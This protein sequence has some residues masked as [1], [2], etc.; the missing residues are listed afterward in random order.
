MLK[1]IIKVVFRNIKRNKWHSILNIGGLSIGL[2]CSALILFYARFELSFDNYH[3]KADRIYRLYNEQPGNSFMGTNNFAVNSAPLGKAM[4]S[5]FPEVESTVNFLFWEGNRYFSVGNKG[6]FEKDIL[7][8][9]PSL[10][11]I[12]DF[13]LLEGNP[14][15]ALTEPN[16]VVLSEDI[17]KKYF[18]NIDPVN[19]TI[20]YNNKIALKVTGVLKKVPQNSHF[21]PTI[22]ISF[23][24]IEKLYSKF[25]GM[26]A[27]GSNSFKTYILLKKNADIN[28]LEKKMPAFLDKYM[29][30]LF[31]E[32]G[33]K[34]YIYHFQPLN[35]VY[36]HS[37]NIN[38]GEGNYNDLQSIYILIALALVI[39]LAACINYVNLSTAKATLKGLEV[40]VRKV[41]GA[42]RKELIRQFLGES[43]IL[44]LIAAVISLLL[45]ELLLPVFSELISESFSSSIIT[46]FP[47]LGSF[48]GL[49]LIVGL[50]A[51]IYPAFVLSSFDPIRVLKGATQNRKSGF[52]SALVVVQFTAAIT[53]IVSSVVILGQLN[54]I[55]TQD[56]G[57]NRDQVLAIKI[58]SNEESEKIEILKNKLLQSTEI[59]NATLT[60]SLPINIGSQSGISSLDNDGNKKIVK[61]YQLY[62]DYDFLDTYEIPVIKGRNFSN[63]FPSDSKNSFIVNQK[64]VDEFGWKDPVG[65]TFSHNDQT[66]KIIGVIK[67]FHMHSLHLPI[68]PLF[69]KLSD[70]YSAYLSLK[71]RSAD[72]KNTV[73]E[74]KETWS[75]IIKNYPIEYSFVNEDFNKMYEKDER[76]SEVVFYSTILAI[77]IASLGLLGLSAFISEQRKKEI[78]I[79]KVLGAS[80]TN[81]VSMLSGK[82]MMLVVLSNI[83]AWPLAYY[84][85]K[86]WLE[87]FSYRISFNIWFFI[88]PALLALLLTLVTISVYAIKTA[89]K[90]PVESLRNE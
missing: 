31:K 13:P 6:F 28:S 41:I 42:E 73:S 11:K 87:E 40:G 55:R 60:S 50:I 89:L 26:F 80:V 8:A 78:G 61:S 15:N 39:L 12:F 72:M 63:R 53:L 88:I 84:F 74:I 47:F 69:V 20:T 85:M 22:I 33:A 1:N 44:T 90:N 36:L 81:V 17:A 52:R 54:Y 79:R 18:G 82:F 35:D 65:K 67:D 68:A 29:G 46:S 32:W 16:S 62:T 75:E 5:D 57:Y 2:A 49:V 70:N 19:K 27:W 23:P 37:N 43:F 86:S 34:K 76:L 83:F 25:K 71:I 4:E 66:G 59:R 77:I 51:G 7:V 9:E 30:D 3:S 24:T 21:I 64:F 48:T 45:I 58:N 38:F 10:F 14:E 56:M